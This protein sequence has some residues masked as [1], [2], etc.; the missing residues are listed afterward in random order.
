M[1]PIFRARRNK[2]VIELYS[3][4]TFDI[5]IQTLKEELDII[6]KNHKGIAKQRSVNQ[7]N[8]YWGVVLPL[9]SDCTG[10]EINECHEILKSIFLSYEVKLKLKKGES[11]I[12]TSKSTSNFTTVQM[13]EYLTK[14]RQWASQELSCYVP[15]P[16]EVFMEN[17]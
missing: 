8:Y 17:E 16:N 11:N 14:V 10:Y 5:Y 9:I 15:L 12:N 13:E 3:K 7:N 6:V 4:Q 2:S 1:I